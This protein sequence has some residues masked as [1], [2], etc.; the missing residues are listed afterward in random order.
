MVTENGHSNGSNTACFSMEEGVRNV[1]RG[2]LLLP[3]FSRFHL[4]D[5]NYIDVTL[6]K[7]LLLRRTLTKTC[8]ARSF[9]LEVIFKEVLLIPVTFRFGLDEPMADC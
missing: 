8:N 1:K 2:A 5:P 7:V 4:N 3:V 6:L 9:S